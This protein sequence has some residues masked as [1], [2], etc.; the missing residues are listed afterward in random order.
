LLTGVNVPESFKM[1][2][3]NTFQLLFILWGMGSLF[4]EIYLREPGVQDLIHSKHEH[5]DLIIIEAFFNECFLGFAHKFNVPVVQVCT[6]GGTAWMGDWV[7]NPNTYS[8]VPD[9]FSHFG[10]R[11]TFWERLTNTVVG[12]FVQ[13]G[14]KYYYLPKQD[15]IARKYF[16]YTDE[17]PS[18]SELETSTALVLVNSHFSLSYPKPLMPN[19]VQVGGMHIKPPQELPDVRSG[20]IIS[21]IYFYLLQECGNFMNCD[22]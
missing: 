8:Y 9:G 14:R 10:D 6:F 15:A 16:N 13:L 22:R 2:D 1:L 18:I 19:F 17:L 21:S 3:L 4:C 12:E 7:G 11:M 5:F 20:K